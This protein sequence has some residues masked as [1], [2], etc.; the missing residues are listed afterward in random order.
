MFVANLL[1]MNYLPIYRYWLSECYNLYK[2]ND[3]KYIHGKRGTYYR[4]SCWKLWNDLTGNKRYNTSHSIDM[5]GRYTKCDL[6]QVSI[7]YTKVIVVQSH[8]SSKKTST[9]STKDLRKTLSI[10]TIVGGTWKLND[11]MFL[12]AVL[13]RLPW[14]AYN[15]AKQQR[16]DKPNEKLSDYTGRGKDTYH[17]QGYFIITIPI[18]IFTNIRYKLKNPIAKVCHRTRI[19]S[20]NMWRNLPHIVVN[21]ATW[22]QQQMM[23]TSVTSSTSDEHHPPNPRKNYDWETVKSGKENKSLYTAFSISD[24]C[25]SDP[26]R[27]CPPA[28][29]RNALGWPVHP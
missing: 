18:M 16:W 22:T 10:I 15:T 23:T 19:T 9:F 28:T 14:C 5:G 4:L 6:P 20:K 26:C 27:A 2:I 3:V 8:L 11:Y 7:I 24:T 1:R 17:N 25:W 21:S 29:E 12:L 13:M